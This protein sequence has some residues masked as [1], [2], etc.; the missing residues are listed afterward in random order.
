MKPQ[1]KKQSLIGNF[2]KR[3]IEEIDENRVAN[4]TIPNDTSPNVANDNIQANDDIDASPNVVMQENVNIGPSSPTTSIPT[5]RGINDLNDLPSDPYDRPHIASYHPNQIDDIR[6]AYLVKG[7]FQPRSH[8]FPFKH[9]Y[10]KKGRFVVTWFNDHKWLEYST[11]VDKAFCLHCYLFKEDVGNQGGRDTWS[12]N[13]KGFYDWSKKGSLTEHVGKVDSH[14][15]KVAQKCHNLMKQ[16]EHI[17]VNL[18]KSTKEEKIANYYR[19]LGSVMSA[20]FCLEN[21][22]PF[23]GHDESEES[24]SQGIFLSVLKLTS[25]NHSEIG[26]YTLGNAKKNNKLTSLMIRKEIIECFAKEVTKNICA[27]IKDDVFGLLVYES[28]DVSLKEQMVVVVRFVDKFGVV[29][30]NFIGIVHVRDT[31]SST[32]KEAIDSLLA[33]NQL[34]IKQVRGQ[35]YDGAS[36]MRGEFKGLKA[37]ILKDNPSAYYIHCFAHELLLVIVAVAKKHP[38]VKTFYEY[39]S[40]VVTTVSASCKRKDMIRETKKD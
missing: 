26:K 40:M 19:L 29:R 5:T 1:T 38:G 17:D 24:N 11:K 34:S 10:G 35:G 3:K 13:S 20:R 9:Y 30:E 14:H 15:L 23:R 2:F 6:R 36:N 16:D 31:A 8:E 33:N 32:L 4:D 27:E 7:A 37:L 22:L 12:S 28:S 21:S 39:L 18:N 25:T